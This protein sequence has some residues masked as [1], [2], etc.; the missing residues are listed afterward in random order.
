MIET[1]YSMI[2]TTNHRLKWDIV[3]KVKS[4]K[5]KDFSGLYEEGNRKHIITI[6]DSTYHKNH[7]ALLETVL[8]ELQH[9]KQVEHKKMKDLPH[10]AAFF[11]A[12][13][14]MLAKYGL[15]KVSKED[16]KEA[17]KLGRLMGNSN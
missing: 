5:N 7:T 2:D 4:A 11:R 12:L 8:H 14:R 15:P 6:V 17:R 13:D 1:I 3:V 16:K 10:D 9:G